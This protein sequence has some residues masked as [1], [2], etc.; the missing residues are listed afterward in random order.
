MKG[1]RLLVGA[2]AIAA[3]GTF[4]ATATA[5]DPPPPPPPPCGTSATP[6]AGTFNGNLTITGQR[7]VEPGQSLTVNGNLRIA[8]G[9]CLQ[10]FNVPVTVR[11]NAT[12]GTGGILGLGYAPEPSSAPYAFTIG[13]NV[14]ANQSGSLFLDGGTIRGN[15]VS[16]GGGRP[17]LNFS[18]KDNTIG[19]NV[20][21][22]GWHG[23]WIGLIRNHVGGNVIFSR[24]IADDLSQLPGSDSSEVVTNDIRGNLICLANT[25]AVQLGDSGGSQNTV[26]GN[27][28]GECAALAE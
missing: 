14:V 21:M 19:G 22:Q 2:C 26:G 1:L 28:I 5:D 17:Y 10:A 7:V 12:V 23:L 4:A 11:G 20:V 16:N 18:V 24:N 8:P 13:G 3:L 27:A 25:P 9:A 6:I 15:L